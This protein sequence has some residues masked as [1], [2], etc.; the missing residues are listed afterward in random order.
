[1]LLIAIILLEN[2]IA[3]YY[4]AYFSV[5]VCTF[6]KMIEVQKIYIPEKKKSVETIKVI[7]YQKYL[8]KKYIFLLFIPKQ[9]Y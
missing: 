6:C 4:L 7:H 8:F 3:R 5:K 2:N 1:M 9:V